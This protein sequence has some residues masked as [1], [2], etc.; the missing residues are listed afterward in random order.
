MSRFRTS[1]TIN[2]PQKQAHTLCRVALSHLGWTISGV[3]PTRIAGQEAM[4]PATSTLSPVRIAVIFGEPEDGGTELT[5]HG[6]S[7]GCEPLQDARVR[8]C[9][10]QL[11]AAIEQQA[12]LAP[13]HAPGPSAPAFRAQAQPTGGWRPTGSTGWPIFATPWDGAPPLPPA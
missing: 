12:I 1:I 7:F 3:A 13:P 5:L 2:M 4:L 6:V 11:L 10:A 8:D 9:V